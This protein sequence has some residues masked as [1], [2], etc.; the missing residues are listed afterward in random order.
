RKMLSI[1]MHRFDSR[2]RLFSMP[3]RLTS[4]G[5]DPPKQSVVCLN[6][7]FTGI[8]RPLNCS[9]L[10]VLRRGRILQLYGRPARSWRQ[11]NRPTRSLN[12]VKRNGNSFPIL[13][14]DKTT[15]EI[16]IGKWRFKQHLFTT[17]SYRVLHDTW[18]ASRTMP[19]KVDRVAVGR[20]T[21]GR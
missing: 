14:Q 15:A 4:V 3:A 10:C 11:L 16:P 19:C 20:N 7:D 13:R 12:I 21:H 5:R 8:V 6:K 1:G 9:Q 18:V 2:L 17:I